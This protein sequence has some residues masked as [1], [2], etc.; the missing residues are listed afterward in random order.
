MLTISTEE[1]PRPPKSREAVDRRMQEDRRKSSVDMRLR[2]GLWYQ[3]HRATRA[4]EFDALPR[5]SYM[6]AKVQEALLPEMHKYEFAQRDNNSPAVPSC[7]L[8]TAVDFLWSHPEL[9][10]NA[11]GEPMAVYTVNGIS[12]YLVR[13]FKVTVID[14]RKADR[15]SAVAAGS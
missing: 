13:N 1:T 11:A 9:G 8:N 14:R 2:V 7:A 5:N 10:C 4:G 15:R 6:R 12:E 3:Y